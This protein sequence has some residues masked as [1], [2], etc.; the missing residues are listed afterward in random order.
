MT[1]QRF[2]CPH[3]G[4]RDEIF[5]QFQ[6]Y[7]GN[8][9]PVCSLPLGRWRRGSK[10]LFL[11]LLGEFQISPKLLGEFH[12]LGV[13][14]RICV[15]QSDHSVHQTDST[16]LAYRRCL[17]YVTPFGG[18]WMTWFC[19]PPLGCTALKDRFFVIFSLSA[20]LKK[21]V[22]VYCQRTPWGWNS[23]N[24]HIFCLIRKEIRAPVFQGSWGGAGNESYVRLQV[25][26]F[27]LFLCALVTSKM[28]HWE[29]GWWLGQ[30]QRG[31]K[32]GRNHPS[33]HSLNHKFTYSFIQ[34]TCFELL[35]RVKHCAK[36]YRF[37]D[38]SEIQEFL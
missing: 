36:C 17:V 23:S 14:E 28:M 16:L 13:V 29:L 19:I 9:M 18:V 6:T 2:S 25:L 3:E 31:W 10:R 5:L 35:F 21:K 32:M 37:W 1:N 27:L 20:N 7:L 30:R 22:C 34:Q 12:S 4:K 33:I 15:Y 11:Q 38:E 26:G 8:W 24:I